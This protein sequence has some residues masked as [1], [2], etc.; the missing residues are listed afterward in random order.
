MGKSAQL[1]FNDPA[2]DLSLLDVKGKEIKLS[3]LWKKK[4]LV[5]AFTRHF[6]CPQCKE[7]TDQL[8]TIK[9]ELEKQGLNLAVITQGTLEQAKAFCKERAPGV[10]CLSD[11]DR[12]AY[13]AYGLERG[14]LYQTLLSPHIWRSNKK[15]KE[16]RGW[17][18]ESPPK[19]QDA[20]VMS[21]TFIVG[22]DGLIRMPYYY[23]DIA[24]HPPVE[25]LLKGLLGMD[26]N[27]PLEGP[28]I[29][30]NGEE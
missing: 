2:P 29:P 15:L 6:G 4:P 27:Q 17:K 16:I 11:P 18:P 3:K 1:T 20:F 12:R 28:L 22:T 25:L 7:M 8:V 21:G 10:Y 19:G 5:L 26:W 9:P 23:E 13:R 14:S 30:E 24:D